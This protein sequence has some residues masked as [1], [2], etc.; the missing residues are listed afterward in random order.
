MP[1]LG[2]LVVLVMP[3]EDV[4]RANAVDFVSGLCMTKPTVAVDGMKM[5]RRRH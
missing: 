3:P 1:L 2:E 5:D 4:T